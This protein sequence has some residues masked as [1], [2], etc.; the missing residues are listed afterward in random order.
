MNSIIRGIPGITAQVTRHVQGLHKAGK[1]IQPGLASIGPFSAFSTQSIKPIW[2]PHKPSSP[3]LP[4][5]HAVGVIQSGYALK[6]GVMD[7]NEMGI[8]S[9]SIS[10]EKNMRMGAVGHIHIK[11]TT[12]A[13]AY[14]DVKQQIAAIKAHN[15]TSSPQVM[16]V[17]PKYG[18]RSEDPEAARAFNESGI[19]WVGPPPESMEYGDK[20]KARE[21]RL[22]AGLGVN[23]GIKLE[24]TKEEQVNQLMDFVNTYGE[25]LVKPL[26]GGGGMGMSRVKN[27]EE[28]LI[29]V[30]N[31]ISAGSATGETEIGAE[32]FL[33]RIRHIEIQILGD[34]HGVRVVGAREC[35]LQDKN[36]KEVESTI[37]YFLV[38][39]VEK[40]KA[41][42]K[43][44]AEKIGYKGPGTFEYGL[45]M[46]EE[47]NT[48]K[49]IKLMYKTAGAEGEEE[50][51]DFFF[52][53]INTR[54]QVEKYVTQLATMIL[55]GMEEY[56]LCLHREL[57][58]NI[59]LH[60]P[61]PES[62][63]FKEKNIVI[64]VRLNALN[65]DSE[66]HSTIQ[67]VDTSSIS[68]FAHVVMDEGP[69]DPHRNKQVGRLMVVVPKGTKG[70][71]KED[72]EFAIQETLKSVRN[73][74]V[75]G[76]RLYLS[77]TAENALASGIF[78]DGTLHTRSVEEKTLNYINY[79]QL[80]LQDQS[81]LIL[82]QIA[83]IAA[84]GGIR[85]NGYDGSEHPIASDF[86]AVEA[87][88]KTLQ[89][90]EKTHLSSAEIIRDYGFDAFIQ[91][92]IKYGGGLEIVATRDEG[93]ADR[94]GIYGNE[95]GQLISLGTTLLPENTIVE[96]P[97]GAIKQTNAR[98]NNT[99]PRKT[100]S[101]HYPTGTMLLTELGRGYPGQKLEDEPDPAKRLFYKVQ[102]ANDLL[103]A[104]V[105]VDPK[106]GKLIHIKKNFAAGNPAHEI[107]E[108]SIEDSKAGFMT[109]PGVS[110]DAEMTPQDT[111]AIAL[112][113]YT[114]M[115][116][117]G[118]V[119]EMGFLKNPGTHIAFTAEVAF[120]HTE[121]IYNAYKEVYN[122]AP[123]TIMVHAHLHKGSEK[124]TQAIIDL[125]KQWREVYPNTPLIVSVGSSLKTHPDIV[126]V[127]KKLFGSDYAQK[128]ETYDAQ[129]QQAH[130]ITAAY[131]KSR[132]NDKT[133]EDSNAPGGARSHMLKELKDNG[134]P[135]HACDKLHDA[136]QKIQS[137]R[138]SVT[139]RSQENLRLGMFIF[140]KYEEEM[141]T[142]GIHL[143]LDDKTFVD[144]VTSFIEEKIKTNALSLE[145][146]QPFIDLYSNWST[147]S[148]FDSPL[149]HSFRTAVLAQ[150]S[151]KA[152]QTKELAPF[153]PDKELANLKALTQR[154]DLT[155]SDLALHMQ[156]SAPKGTEGFA[157]ILTGLD[158]ATLG[159][160]VLF[161]KIET[162]KP[163][164][165]YINGERKECQIT[166]IFRPDDTGYRKIGI[167]S[168]DFGYQTYS[169]PDVRAIEALNMEKLRDVPAFDST[170]PL[171]VKFD[172]KGKVIEMTSFEVTIPEGDTQTVE[173]GTVEALKMQFKIKSAPLPPGRYRFEP[174][175]SEGDTLTEF[176]LK[177]TLGTFVKLDSTAS[178]A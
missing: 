72:W 25:A 12:P 15:Q 48:P 89:T 1:V 93:Q 106:T 123:P 53:E 5:N 2:T 138:V 51:E 61:L 70:S 69:I 149:A 6:S 24:G 146:P 85:L 167:T 91:V 177:K 145:L 68:P 27:R 59:V 122:V 170:N 154:Q 63:Q 120:K 19:R 55:Y 148:Y 20:Q 64:E 141:A 49:T 151:L 178:V 111:K 13:L 163:L 42:A 82:Q 37:P 76:T 169:S 176:A 175:F 90:I 124:Q 40:I 4:K 144:K 97:G 8:P 23:P 78:E 74:S 38:D 103:E 129:V 108:T 92:L 80:S 52:I 150:S 135:E 77:K 165:Y 16:Y 56:E 54:F 125:V 73:L 166:D 164:Y 46:D 115:K 127:S 126:T 98:L 171:H 96:G 88:L 33:P 116:K 159:D 30:E 143:D 81:K 157:T 104:G 155:Y 36:A 100:Y 84:N 173:V 94:A 113:I 152:T 7:Y 57:M 174:N 136:G 65:I 95:S 29:A 158:R 132:I 142:K 83:D 34:E 153:D 107:A 112:K 118:V 117:E 43:L 60:I 67:D 41:D 17:D 105:P 47:T 110:W 18:N 79:S 28:A 134:L 162:E 9:V 160:R 130:K 86:D 101:T 102:H 140:K 161:G 128:A 32:V 139:P 31:G 87:S 10:H 26:S 44:F 39:H 137:G 66:Y 99:D 21:A 119:P 3:I 147:K 50:S 156:F 109:A 121:A 58:R 133:K 71:D 45:V 35:S 131:S 62:S 114:I 11:G 75:N 172:I 168:E 14:M 22:D